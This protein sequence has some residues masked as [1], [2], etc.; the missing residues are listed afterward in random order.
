MLLLTT[1]FKV[2]FEEN[3]FLRKKKEKITFHEENYKPPL[4]QISN[5]PSIIMSLDGQKLEADNVCLAVR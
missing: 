5:G 1:G 4:P 3:N 2:V